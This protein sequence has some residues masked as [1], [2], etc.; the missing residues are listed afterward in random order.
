[1]KIEERTPTEIPGISDWVRKL[2]SCSSEEF[3]RELQSFDKW[4][5]QRMDDLS[6]VSLV[7][8]RID[9]LLSEGIS[10]HGFPLLELLLDKTILILQSSTSKA[11]YN[12][13]EELISI[14]DF[15]EW[16]LVYKAL[17]VIHLL[18]NRV[19]PIVKAT[20]AHGNPLLTRK[21]YVIG[22]GSNL[23]C[24]TPVPLQ[25]ICSN[26]KIRQLD[27]QYV[28]GDEVITSC[29]N[30]PEELSYVWLN[31]KRTNKCITHKR[32]RETIVASQLLALSCFMQIPPESQTLQDFCRSLPELWLLP[33][34]SE[35]LRMPI[36]PE[37][38]IQAI[39]L[40]SGILVMM[41][42]QGTRYDLSHN[43]LISSAHNLLAA[44]QQHGLMQTLLRDISCP[45]TILPVATTENNQFI[46]SLLHLASIVA[47]YK[48]RVD[49][50]HVPGMTC[51]LLL[52]LQ[53]SQR[54]SL[55]NTAKA[56]R[57]LSVVVSHSI[58][59]FKEIH[60]L[61]TVL[62]LL[63][64]E[65]GL[66]NAQED[67]ARAYLIRA[68]L[69]LLKIALTKWD[70][71]HTI[72]H[73]EVRTI[74]DSG[75]L[76]SLH[77]TYECRLFDIYEP[78]LQLL[79]CLVNDYL[80]LV[81]ELIADGTVQSLLQSLEGKLPSNPKLVSVIARF[82]CYVAANKQGAE[83]IQQ[84]STIA[85]LLQALGSTEGTALSN[86][87]A[88]SIGESLQDLMMNIPSLLD[89][90]EDGCIQLVL[91]LNNTVVVSRELFFA[92]L[93][94]VGRLLGI[95]FGFSE[96]LVMGFIEKGGLEGF[97]NIF[98]LP[99]P[100]LTYSNEFHG[101]AS[102][103]KYIPLTL[104]G[105]VFSK[106]LEF[107]NRQLTSLE[108]YTGRLVD[109]ENFAHITSTPELLHLLT[110]TDSYVEML[111]LIL[112]YGTGTAAYIDL[113][114]STLQRLADYMRILIAE[115]ARVS[116]F[117]KANERV[118]K[119]FNQPIDISDI[120]NAGLK[121]FEENFYF[122]CQLSV[123]KLYR[124]AA[125]MT[126]ARGRQ[127]I[128][129]EAGIK[130]SKNMG[131]ILTYL[132]KII[133]I[134]VPEQSK[135]YYFCLQLSDILKIL[136]QDQVSNP[137]TILTFYQSGGTDHI[138]SFLVQLRHISQNLLNSEEK[139]YDLVN[140]LQILWNLCGKFLE[141]LAT[142][143]FGSTST[144]NAVLRGL[145]YDTPKE[146]NRKM[147]IVALD[148]ISRL[149]YLECGIYST[150]FARSALEILKSFSDIEKPN[151][152]AR[153][154]KTM[155][156]MGFSESALLQ[157]ARITNSSDSEKI[158]EYLVANKDQM[159]HTSEDCVEN[160]HRILINSLP[161]I[162]TLRT[163]VADLLCKLCN[164]PNAPHREICCMLLL[165]IGILV[166]RTLGESCLLEAMQD[167]T[168]VHLLEVPTGFEQLGA[169]LHV[170][171]VL[172]SKSADILEITMS[173]RFTSHAIRIME[174]F[175]PDID[176]EALRSLTPLFSLIDALCKHSET[177]EALMQA[178]CNLINT[179][180]N[181]QCPEQADLNSLLQVLA[182]L[183][184]NPHHAK[185]LIES[186]A[187]NVLLTL[188]ANDTGE[189][190]KNNLTF[191]GVLI[192][193]LVE[194]PYILQSSFEITLLQSHKNGVELKE[195][196][197]MFAAQMQRSQE[198]FR[199]AFDNAC[200]VVKKN[201]QYIV[202]LAKERKE[203][204]SEKWRVAAIT[205]LCLCEIFEGE[206]KGQEFIVPSQQ[207]ISILADIFQ[208]Y[209]VLIKDIIPLTVKHNKKFLSYLLRNIIPF[210]YTLQLLDG[211]IVFNF[212]V[213]KIP[214]S[215]E[216]YQIWV[217]MTSKLI[218]SLT[219]K[220]ACKQQNTAV[221]DMYNTV[222]L[223]N[224]TPILK[225][226]KR[227][228][229]ELKEILQEQTKKAWFS[230]EKS[231]AIVR[232]VVIIVMQLLREVAKS[233]YT[234]NNPAEIA[235]MLIG[236]S[237]N[238]VKLLSDAA[239]G[240]KLNSKKAGSMMN[241][242]LAPLE[243]L[244]KYNI[245]FTLH[246]SKPTS[247]QEVEEVVE[248]PLEDD[249]DKFEIYEAEEEYDGSGHSSSSMEEQAEEE[250][251]DMDMDEDSDSDD[252]EEPIDI[253][254][255]ANEE[256]DDE[257]LLEESDPIE[258]NLEN[259]VVEGR[260]T[261]AFWADDVEEEADPASN[262]W[263][264][265]R[266][267]EEVLVE[268]H[269]FDHRY[270]IAA[271]E[272]EIW[273]G[274]RD[275]RELSGIG[276]IRD[277]RDLRE[278]REIREI[279]EIRDLSNGPRHWDIVE[280]EDSGQ[281]VSLFR[282]LESSDNDFWQALMRR[283]RITPELPGL[284]NKPEDSDS[285]IQDFYQSVIKNSSESQDMEI[286]APFI[287]NTLDPVFLAALPEDI[288]IELLTQRVFAQ[289]LSSA[290]LS[291]DFLQALPE[292]L[293]AELIQTRPDPS[294][295]ID[296]ATFIAS[297]TPDL[298]REILITAN[299]ELLASLTPELAAEA[300]VLQERIINR[301]HAHVERQAPV[302]QP[303]E[304]GKVISEIVA[305][306]KLVAALA[307]VEDSFLEVLV[308]GIYL[309]N[310][311]N[312]DI[313]A[314]L[315]LN[316]SVQTNVRAKLLDALLCLLL[317][318]GPEKEFP[319]QRLYGSET[320]LENYS[321]V[322]AIVAGRILDLLLYL[323]QNNPKIS[324]E[325]LVSSKFRLPLIKAIRGNEEIKGLSSLL[326]LTQH[327]LYESSS[328]HLNPLIN[329]IS[330]I[331][332][333]QESEV[334]R[335]EETEIQE[336]CTLL[337]YESLNESSV[338]IVVEIVTRLARSPDNKQSIESVLYNSFSVLGQEIARNL[339]ALE[340]S[341]DGLKELQLLRL[342]KVYKC[343]SEETGGLECMWGPL[344]DALN[345]ITQR[346]S[347]FAST[348]SPTLS[349]LL[350]VIE[351]FFLS[352]IGTAP[353]ECFQRFCDKNRKVLN[354]LVK[355]N[356]A[357]LQDT[358]HS[359]VT[360]FPVLLDFENKRTHF[361][362][363][364]RKLK[365]DRNFDTIRLQ[366]RRAEVFM[367][368]YHQLKTR[369]PE[370][371]HGKL[372]VQ[373]VGEDG[374]DAGGLTREWYELLAREMFNPNYALFIPS[375]N[376]VS[377]QPNCMSSINVEHLEFF[378]FI[379]RIIGKALC[380]GYSLDVYFTRSFY[381]H[382]LGQEVTYQD[383]EDLDP[384]FYKSLKSLMDINLN[385]NELHEYYFAYEEEEFGTLQLKE[386]ESGGIHKRVTEENKM[387][388]IKLLCDMKMTQNIRLQTSAFL[389][390][391]YDLITKPI[392]SIFDSKEL[393]LLIS[394]LPEVDLED[395]KQ[396]TEYHN[397]TKDSDVI[398]W[399]WE[400]L[401]EFSHEERAEFLQFV[402]GSSKVPLEGFKALPGMS[403]V[404]K[405]QVHKSFT[406]PDRLPTAHTCMNQLDLPEYPSIEI[407]R[408]RL[409]LATSEGKEGFGFM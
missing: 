267:N 380:D 123:R 127:A 368:S 317:Q 129:E 281:I 112:Q 392:I 65:L 200:V 167:T 145:G 70:P 297:L 243:L 355:Q 394:G 18:V 250:N 273:P 382:I 135:A 69:R 401:Q 242:I 226:R 334:P 203:I 178:L 47:D 117:S 284:R 44:W 353:T 225:A 7:L 13:V 363:E 395:L 316:L 90:A 373:F 179:H 3:L 122:T 56:V 150:A 101:V 370:E 248:E 14:L 216:C 147:Q 42:G 209:P 110:A 86:D 320:Y 132:I 318:F 265:N 255:E 191:Y 251:E 397:Y 137:A 319:P 158:M 361:R 163:N 133:S 315:M 174:A 332:E 321:Q 152:D 329:L 76:N 88:T 68:V 192:K 114:C 185:I 256:E 367:D 211:K 28:Q 229:S 214:V 195:F 212:P 336:I 62:V 45:P 144:G 124:F 75:L 161:A 109:L 215:Q 289:D 153:L 247:T 236:D 38:H 164:K 23:N 53:N 15:S 24:S 270:Q 260:N 66:Y 59:M 201:R 398:Q 84:F 43:H 50:S 180:K 345:T 166:H 210:R 19:T 138:Y 342:Y 405:F 269:I 300:R 322:Y 193:Q 187:L 32:E 409:K 217:K 327:K 404:Q 27:F 245:N 206:Q 49:S 359:L 299:E 31:R 374:V 74:I 104:T 372:R 261:E 375:A 97:L 286:E 165:Q 339:I 146:V 400:V 376:G 239:K 366:V 149:N 67:P 143:K 92:Q 184:L 105:L 98:K 333:K 223:D 378:K 371:M 303:K 268:R 139:P 89:H 54:L 111:R 306:D 352:H 274:I 91:S 95:L 360:K 46:S 325:F 294:A 29:S 162:P 264:Q 199:L 57:I 34:V 194:D 172:C 276:E 12:S 257:D 290:D 343:I 11:L 77:K 298:R 285:M 328:S 232:A 389:E 386:L 168:A 142:G 272:D 79:C 324:A 130:M 39:H 354:I 81:A 151:L 252:S 326:S 407:L 136:L 204:K 121:S 406:G 234:N 314:S 220:Q 108:D 186:K 341:V 231:I 287:A 41:E 80:P 275:M 309:L 347:D 346:D 33:A 301:R 177:D 351:T 175:S 141:C 156:D 182:T 258:E 304:D 154:I 362:S 249:I 25:Q 323:A 36:S 134:E 4:N 160:L 118:T 385:D 87:L 356:P 94:N 338:K 393:E 60:G 170:L 357:L 126:C 331:I 155:Q 330:C 37:V 202:E 213:T 113:L 40:F 131:N 387:E 157:A 140:S 246:L 381:K 205:C 218:K 293:R 78:C 358:F 310:P 30:I 254:L 344:T 396:N 1:M 237:L 295:E 349:K 364:I 99:I 296:N 188:K 224:N 115:Q 388:Y 107:L 96:K 219:F 244:T 369:N 302:R 391:F 335:M 228:F 197:K 241:L 235:R 408:N 282:E 35:L 221:A 106:I 100:P 288:R 307:Q 222:I 116:P 125:R 312:R 402:T 337:S 238:M 72:A 308:K 279:R 348:A 383:M 159:L 10:S 21:L 61:D 102:C 63:V 173:L 230:S 9:D 103:F 148:C 292:E 259:I 350:P 71:S 183:T 280:N 283:N 311:I 8:D 198:I 263:I 313:L 291:E 48:Y 93:T 16:I 6:S 176:P 51:S 82:L 277:L 169:C 365:P 403:G 83:M 227:I 253:E 64:K 196:L 2:N 379:G 58:D 190:I 85:R 120:E 271:E 5:W 171:S 208:S 119:T 22:L 278:L 128:S 262:V 377:F 207:L 181:T 73:S 55:A 52:L 305:D 26:A 240:V 266:Q 20:K 390:G 17:Q 233:P 189:K 399:M 340:T 384:D